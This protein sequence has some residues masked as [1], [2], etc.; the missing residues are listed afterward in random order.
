MFPSQILNCFVEV[1]LRRQ[2]IAIEIRSRNTDEIKRENIFRA[3]VGVRKAAWKR[4]QT[5][6]YVI[7][8]PPN[9]FS[10]R[11]VLLTSPIPALTHS[12]RG[13]REIFRRGKAINK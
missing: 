9:K 3:R 1:R 12:S 5:P 8:V 10:R 13:G 4:N 2:R 7:N 6:G 11:L